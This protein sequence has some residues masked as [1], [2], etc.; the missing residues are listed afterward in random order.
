MGEVGG[1]GAGWGGR[2]WKEMGWGWKDGKGGVAHSPTRPVHKTSLL[3]PRPSGADEDDFEE[4][5]EEAKQPQ[6]K[7]TGAAA[8]LLGGLPLPR[9]PSAKGARPSA[10][11]A[12]IM[13]PVSALSPGWV[14]MRVGRGQGQ[15]QKRYLGGQ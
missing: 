3:L 7:P 15:G 12:P 5:E 10:A 11:A 9:I 8:K 1:D 13:P 4:E 2:E 14:L 6:H